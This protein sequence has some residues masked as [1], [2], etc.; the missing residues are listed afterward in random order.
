MRNLINGE[1]YDFIT[2]AYNDKD[3]FTIDTDNETYQIYGLSNKKRN[4]NLTHSNVLFL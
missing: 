4:E 3:V 2:M 1:L